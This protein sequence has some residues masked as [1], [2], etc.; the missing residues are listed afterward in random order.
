MRAF[1]SSS[2]NALR[3][4]YSLSLSLSLSIISTKEQLTIK[5]MKRG[6]NAF[7]GSADQAAKIAEWREKTKKTG[8]RVTSLRRKIEQHKVDTQQFIK[9]R[10]MLDDI[11][12][13]DNEQQRCEAQLRSLG[14]YDTEVNA[15]KDRKR[16]IEEIHKRLCSVRSLTKTVGDTQTVDNARKMLSDFH[17]FINNE[18][19]FLVE[20]EEKFSTGILTSSINRHDNY[21][22]SLERIFNGGESV[23]RQRSCSAEIAGQ[24]E[25]EQVFLD[26]LNKEREDAMFQLRCIEPF[27]QSSTDDVLEAADKILKIDQE[28]KKRTLKVSDS[29][30]LC[31]R[32]KLLFPSLGLKDIQIGLAD[33]EHKKSYSLACQNVIKHAKSAVEYIAED[34]KVVLEGLFKEVKLQR[35]IEST[36]KELKHKKMVLDSKLNAQRTIFEEKQAAIKKE[37]ELQ[38]LREEQEEA[39]R[40]NKRLKEMQYRLKLLEDYEKR[41]KELKEKEE[42]LRAIK[43]R[44]EEAD[45]LERMP[46]NAARVQFRQQILEERRKE[47]NQRV[48]EIEEMKRQKEEAIQ[49]FFDAIH[50]RIGVEADFNRVLKGTKSSEQTKSYVSFAEAS[51]VDLHGYSD[52][53]I[54]QDPRVRLYHA[55]LEAG[56]HKSVYG[57]QKISEGYHIPQAQQLSQGNPFG[58]YF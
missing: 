18:K 14:V 52:E 28:A 37:K 42:E 30:A 11:E 38:A 1:G 12:S 4:D 17:Q 43:Q 5:G 35:E 34:H 19:N 53:K 31:D 47:H 20:E 22:E 46:V 39:V 10:A 24:K 55:L 50:E 16:L 49:R 26:T 36:E 9:A 7:S 57:R 51:T 41:K 27:I 45:K 2:R 29:K 23:I 13:L 32:M 40:R 8:S 54:M 25:L 44:E 58:S 56:L 15:E 21:E 6:I 48:L 3:N 33:A